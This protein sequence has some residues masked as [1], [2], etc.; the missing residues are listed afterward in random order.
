MWLGASHYDIMSGL[1]QDSPKTLNLKT[2]MMQK[3]SESLTAGGSTATSTTV[4]AILRLLGAEVV[5]GSDNS[6]KRHLCGLG[7]IL[8]H[9]GGLNAF[10]LDRLIANILSM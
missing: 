6:I 1:Q 5:N 3:I 8:D 4:V 2:V 9:A 10:G 7:M